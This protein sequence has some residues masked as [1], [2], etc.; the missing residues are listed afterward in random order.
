MERMGLWG[1]GAPFK[2]FDQFIST[3]EKKG[4]GKAPCFRGNLQRDVENLDG[5]LRI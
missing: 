3:V 5:F 1:D 4:L 2:S